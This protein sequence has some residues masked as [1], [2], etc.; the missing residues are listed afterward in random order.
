MKFVSCSEAEKSAQLV[1]QEQH[2]A[3]AK[4]YRDY[5]KL[6]C[7]NSCTYWNSLTEDEKQSHDMLDGALHISFDYAQNVLIPHSPQQI[8]P[9]Y[10]KTP[11]KCH[12]FGICSESYPRKLI[13]SLLRLSLLTRVQMRLWVIFIIISI[14][15]T[16]LNSV[17][18]ISTVI[19]VVDKIRT[20]LL[21]QYSSFVVEHWRD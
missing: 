6:Q 1:K 5:Y 14:L 4:E 13:T 18:W 15:T 8:G 12:L 7:E 3:L 9:I 19:I 21:F 20:M 10:F 17:I 16:L 11:R 2:L